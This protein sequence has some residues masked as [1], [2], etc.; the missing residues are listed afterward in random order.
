MQTDARDHVLQEEF[1]ESSLSDA[2]AHLHSMGFPGNLARATQ[3]SPDASAGHG[4]SDDVPENAATIH[5][6][7]V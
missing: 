6:D 4:Q 1:F 3:V 5:G 2:P 7:D